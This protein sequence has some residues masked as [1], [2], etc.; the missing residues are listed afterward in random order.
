[1]NYYTSKVCISLPTELLKQLDAVAQSRYQ[2][3]SNAVNMAVTHW[4]NSEP[5]MMRIA[6]RVRGENGL[7]RQEELAEFLNA[8]QIKLLNEFK[9][10]EMEFEALFKQLSHADYFKLLEMGEI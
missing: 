9:N 1:M 7:T 6:A 8:K 10:G 5:A 2:S 3:R 4:I